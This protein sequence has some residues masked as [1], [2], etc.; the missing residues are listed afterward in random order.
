MEKILK[1]KG[2]ALVGALLLGIAVLGS[3]FTGKSEHKDEP[4]ANLNTV[5]FRYQP[6]TGVSD[7]YDQM[8]VNN[9]ANWKPGLTACTSQPNPN[10][11]CSIEVDLENTVD[12]AGLEIDNSV[13]TINTSFV[14]AQRYIV[15]SPTGSQYTNQRNIKLP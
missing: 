6:P 10:T 11:P 1:N 4:K 12:E 14:S 13:V 5:I 8:H 15:A 3:A 9:T 2:K 7:P